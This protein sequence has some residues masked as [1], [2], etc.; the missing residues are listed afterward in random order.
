MRSELEFALYSVLAPAAA[1]F[2]VA[3]LLPRVLPAQAAARYGL[4]AGAAT[5]FVVGYLL[6]PNW[7][8]IVPAR[9][10]QWLLY[11]AP[12][13]A[14][15]GAAS[16]A[17]GAL[18]WERW[19]LYGL[20]AVVAAWQLVPTWSTLQPPRSAIIP[21]LA[22]YLFSLMALLAALPERLLGRLFVGLLT[23][24]AITLG[25]LIAIGVSLKFGRVGAV[26]AAA[27]AGG[28]AHVCFRSARSLSDAGSLSTTARGLIPLFAVLTGGLAFVGAIEPQPKLYGLFLAPAAPLALWLFAA[29]PLSRIADV[30]AIAL[31]SAAVL[32]VLAT[33]LV[34]VV[35]GSGAGDS[36]Y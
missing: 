19:L 18:A 17:G 5:A 13:A 28:W 25:L 21:L 32:T 6:L 20:L 22:A 36:A 33:A 8:A 3:R 11:L 16:L 23:A 26:A 24:S 9:H 2:A 15:I 7:A 29:G 34:W 4:A 10:W 35:V 1:A 12:A 31:Q 27:L 14:A 30:K